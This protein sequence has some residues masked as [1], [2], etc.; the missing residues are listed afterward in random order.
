MSE[1]WFCKSNEYSKYTYLRQFCENMYEAILRCFSHLKPSTANI[2]GGCG[3]ETNSFFKYIHSSKG[4][5]KRNQAHQQAHLQPHA[6][7]HANHRSTFAEQSGKQSGDLLALREIFEV[8]VQNVLTTEEANF[9]KNISRKKR[10]ELCYHLAS[11]TTTNRGV[12]RTFI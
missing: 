7:A 3:L 2:P 10:H 12:P 8:V 9:S 6:R 11:P 5:H 1:K 4:T